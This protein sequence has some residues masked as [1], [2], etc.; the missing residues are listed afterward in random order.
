MPEAKD[1]LLEPEPLLGQKNLLLLNLEAQPIEDLVKEVVKVA[2]LLGLGTRLPVA[3]QFAL[4][5]SQQ[6][7]YLTVCC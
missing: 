3:E 7:H 4:W 2:W 1:S 6:T 5:E